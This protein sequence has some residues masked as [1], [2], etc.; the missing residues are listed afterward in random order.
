MSSTKKYLINIDNAGTKLHL[1]PDYFE[2]LWCN[3]DRKKELSFGGRMQVTK[4]EALAYRSKEKPLVFEGI[5][6]TN[7]R[8]C[9]NCS[10]R[11]WQSIHWDIP[12]SRE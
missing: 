5:L 10:Y 6:I 8:E 9:K 4:E 7:M 11:N 3:L 1:N 12:L 2:D